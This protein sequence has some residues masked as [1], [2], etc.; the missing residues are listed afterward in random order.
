MKRIVALFLGAVL[1]LCAAC[2]EAVAPVELYTVAVEDSRSHEDGTLLLETSVDAAEFTG[3]GS[4]ASAAMTETYAQLF[5]SRAAQDIED[6]FTLASDIYLL[7]GSAAQP[8]EYRLEAGT[9]RSDERVFVLTLTTRTCVMDGLRAGTS[10]EAVCF[11]PADGSILTLDRLTADGS[12]PTADIA[13]LLTE[14]FLATEYAAEGYG[15][16]AATAGELI[17]MLLGK[18][19]YQWYITDR[20]VFISNPYDLAP[21]Y[22][23]GFELEL[24]AHEL[25]GVID[26]EWF[27]E[28]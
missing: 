13:A 6:W 4:G 12:D 7:G 28:N 24:T 22:L 1:L 19:L 23:G 25:E 14:K 5:G 15:Y 16:D 2:G 20:F 9:L 27:A 21:D 17:E 3:G 18:D 11:S 26:T 8:G 10:R